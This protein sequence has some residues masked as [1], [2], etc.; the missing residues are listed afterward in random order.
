MFFLANC[1]RVVIPNAITGD[2][3]FCCK[4]LTKHENSTPRLNLIFA[5]QVLQFHLFV[6][7]TDSCWISEYLDHFQNQHSWAPKPKPDKPAKSIYLKLKQ[8]DSLQP[9]YGLK[10]EML[11]LALKAQSFHRIGPIWIYLRRLLLTPF[12][13][14]LFKT[15]VEI[16]VQSYVLDWSIGGNTQVTCISFSHW[17]LVLVTG[18]GDIGRATVGL[19]P[20][21]LTSWHTWPLPVRRLPGLN[22]WKPRGKWNTSAP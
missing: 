8:I 19:P 6:Q 7:P 12:S 5:I 20:V 1:A 11:C 3:R 10:S 16:F 9:I 22:C 15:Y 14:S 2:R 18:I 4:N 17:S 21:G 13:A